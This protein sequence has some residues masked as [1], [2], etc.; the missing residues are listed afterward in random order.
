MELDSISEAI[1]D[2]MLNV[3]TV[4]SHDELAHFVGVLTSAN[5][6]E[7]RSEWGRLCDDGIIVQKDY[8]YL[9]NNIHLGEVKNKL[10]EVL[11]TKNISA[12]AIGSHIDI[13]LSKNSE[14]LR[15]YVSL[16]GKLETKE[17]TRSIPFSDYEWVNDP[18]PTC[19]EL[20]KLGIMFVGTSA[21]KRHSYRFYYL[22]R[23]PFDSYEMLSNIVLRH[24]NIEGL[25]DSEWRLLFH[26]LFSRDISLPYDIL[27]STVDMTEAEVRECINTLKDRGQLVEKYGTVSLVKGAYLPVLEYFSKNVYP[28]FKNEIVS[29]VKKRVTEGLSNLYPF[30]CTKRLNELPIGDTRHDIIRLKIIKKSE[31]RELEQLP[32]LTHLGLVMDL[33]ENIVVL[34]DVVKEIE[35]WIRE[36]LKS[37]LIVIPARDAYLA[38]SVLIDMFSRCE[39]YVKIQD[40]YLGE[41]TFQILSRYVPEELEIKVLTGQSIGRG[42][43]IEDICTYIERLKSERKGNFEIMFIGDK[44][45]EA[46]FHDRFIIS[47]N[48]CWAIGTSLKQIGRGKDTTVDEITVTEKDEKIEPAFNWNWSAKKEELEKKGLTRLGFNDWKATLKSENEF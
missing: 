25:S 37:S 4:F 1:L 46:P 13:E 7:I 20:V 22:R 8:Q 31:I 17:D 2:Y 33:G 24:L 29:K 35:N 40:P 19:D 21:S 16:L 9:I 30:M 10:N 27:K 26:L 45:G 41:E 47:K 3:T 23:W 14:K 11:V 42:E 5:N 28:R 34:V 43:A 15:G 6:E 38:R 12:D 32:D 18:G 44:Q 36:S 39:S 48:N